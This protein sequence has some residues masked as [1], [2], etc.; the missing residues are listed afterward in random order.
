[1]EV[2][3]VAL[4]DRALELASQEL[5][6]DSPLILGRSLEYRRYF[7]SI[8]DGDQRWPV[9][10]RRLSAWLSG[11]LEHQLVHDLAVRAVLERLDPESG[12]D[13][14]EVLAAIQTEQ[15]ARDLARWGRPLGVRERLA[16]AGVSNP[17]ASE[18]ISTLIRQDLLRT[19]PTGF[20][21]S[22]ALRR[23]ASA[24]LFVLVV[25]GV[26]GFNLW[27]LLGNLPLDA[28]YLTVHVVGT[29][30]LCWWLS[31]DIFAQARSAESAVRA[32]NEALRPRP[33]KAKTES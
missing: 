16:V 3:L 8:L 26:M 14:A 1:M 24:W 21:S 10:R 18:E 25:S 31:K 11:L 17:A 2:P 20:S 9:A 28:W 22:A 5:P 6:P 15:S 32:A 33:L 7:D 27:I 12:A 13:A 30:G 4:V 23:R 19:D 29:A